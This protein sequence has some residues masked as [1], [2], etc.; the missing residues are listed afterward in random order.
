MTAAEREA[1]R[2]GVEQRILD[3]R[4]AAGVHPQ[5][6][7]RAAERIVAG[8]THADAGSQ[9]WTLHSDNA[10]VGTAWTHARDGRSYLADLDVSA[11]DAAGA[12]AAIVAALAA[13][14]PELLVFDVPAGDEVAAA[15]LSS[16]EAALQGT[17][18]QL[19]L[20]P[21]VDAPPRVVLRSMTDQEVTSYRGQLVAAY[22]QDL[23]DS[24][25]FLTLEA[26]HEASAS[27]T[28]ELL[29]DG[30]PVPGHHL[31]TAYD[32]EKAVG[33]LWIFAVDLV[34]FI[35]DLEVRADQRRR[36][37]GRELLDAGARAARDLGADVLGLNVFGHNEPARAMYER[38]GYLTT[39]QTWRISLT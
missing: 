30:P 4:L 25:G 10:T 36:G 2:P 6:A 38:A 39:E 32:G 34:A 37:Y 11:A 18:M 5:L 20:A 13:Q 26:A 23:F 9:A 28:E 12:L 8:T 16:T 19:D 3:R 17:Q 35:Y 33:N 22:A 7:A 27:Q 29:P 24:G 15:A 14:G 21:P 1:A 31:W